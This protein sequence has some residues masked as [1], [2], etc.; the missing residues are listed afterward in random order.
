MSP[1]EPEEIPVVRALHSGDLEELAR[2]D[3]RILGRSRSAWLKIK[4]AEALGEGV[5]VSLGAEL[6]GVLVGF[7]MGSVYYGEYGLPEPVATIETIEV[8]PDFRGKGVARAL[9]RQFATNLRALRIA[10]VQTQV[11]WN[12][13]TLLRFLDRVGFSPSHRIC[14]QRELDPTRDEET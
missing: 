4:L 2:I 8:H 7:L 13:W 5:R 12:D 11:D 14:L 3:S 9:W 6:H 1:S 10:R